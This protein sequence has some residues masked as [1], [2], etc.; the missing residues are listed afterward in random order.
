MTFMC[1][2]SEQQGGFGVG[3][4]FFRVTPGH[5]DIG[6]GRGSLLRGENLAFPG[7]FVSLGPQT[8][9]SFPRKCNKVPAAPA[10]DTR[11]HGVE[12]MPCSGDVP[13]GSRAMTQ[14]AGLG[15][16][17]WHLKGRVTLQFPLLLYPIIILHPVPSEPGPKVSPAGSHGAS[18]CFW[19]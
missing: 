17:C 7:V 5:G 18:V 19:S 16:I 9:C 8:Q 1:H 2:P 11:D 12:L 14:L 13:G 10:G 15:E 6:A 3:L 4:A